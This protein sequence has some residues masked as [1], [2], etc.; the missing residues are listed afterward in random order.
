MT[1][2]AASSATPIPSD[3]VL[4]DRPS[5]LARPS[6]RRRA[7][8]VLSGVLVLAL[9]L[10]WGL[11]SLVALLT[12]HEADH[13]FHQLTG[14]GV[15]LSVLW[16]AGPVALLVSSWR[17]RPVP[18][19]AWPAHAAFVLA[20]VVTASFV[21]GDGV[22]VL[23]AIVAV[24]AAL[25]WWAVPALPRL[26][27]LVDG[28]DPVRAP[29]ALLGAALY[30]PYVV[31]QRHLQAT[32][33]DE[34]AE[35]THYFDMAWVAVAVVLLLVIAAISGRARRTAVL[36]G[37]AGVV[38]GV[39]GLLLVHPTTWFVLAALHGG[40]VLGAAVLQRRTSVVRPSGS[41]TSV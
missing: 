4:R 35:M 25:L 3:A 37:G 31:A 9:P 11:G 12:G 33:H 19:W 41:R 23:A 38:M 16:A 7:A 21:P 6:R 1:T 20:S 27:G 30:A 15:L 39:G 8:L 40:A 26:R 10:L 34:H 17:G 5:D 18:G 2:N 29:L 22:R 13:R 24:T 32:R 14:E 28:L 36:A